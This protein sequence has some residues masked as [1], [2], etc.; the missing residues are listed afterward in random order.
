MK[1]SLEWLKDHLDTEASVQDIAA[2]LNRIGIEVEAIEDP[3]D[4]LKGFLV[5]E[6]LTAQPHPD[7]DKLQ[8]LTVDAGDGT[9]LQV[10]CGAPN[11]RA[12]MKGVLGLPGAVVPVNGMELR[13]SAIR[14]VESNGMM[15]SVRELELG[16]DHQGIIELPTDAPVG[17]S[18]AEYHGASPIFDVAITPNRP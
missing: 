17:A 8:V 6:V 3:A 5:A 1:F 7:A 16:D 2:T 11:A 18:F 15:C 4:R 9:P 14:G 12:G 10:V 13:K